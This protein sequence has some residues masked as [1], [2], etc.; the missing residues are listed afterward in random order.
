[1]RYFKSNRYYLIPLQKLLEK[2][3]IETNSL[4]IIFTI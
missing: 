2:Y 3:L 1:M 4:I